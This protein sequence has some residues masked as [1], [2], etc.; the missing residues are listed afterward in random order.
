M[1]EDE[2][3]GRQTKSRIQMG[4]ASQSSSHNDHLQFSA[5]TLK[6]EINGPRAG[7]HVA[8]NAVNCVNRGPLVNWEIRDTYPIDT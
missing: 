7:P 2:V 4:P 5:A 6:P 1:F 3:S 8:A